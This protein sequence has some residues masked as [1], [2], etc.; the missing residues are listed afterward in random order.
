MIG[1][2]RQ[3]RVKLLSN[4][5]WTEVAIG[6]LHVA[7]PLEFVSCLRLLLCSS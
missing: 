5:V 1:I 6:E 3:L 2:F 4:Q 7:L